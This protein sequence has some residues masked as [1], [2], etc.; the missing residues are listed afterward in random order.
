LQGLQFLNQLLTAGVSDGSGAVAVYAPLQQQIALAATLAVHPQFTTRAKSEEDLQVAIEALKFL[1]NVNAVIGPIQA[2]FFSSFTFESFNAKRR[3]RGATA[4]PSVDSDEDAAGIRSAFAY[5]KS[6]F[7]QVEDIWQVVGWTFNCSVR[8]DG[9]WQAWKPW[10]EFLLDILED[11]WDERDELARRTGSDQH[12]QS[13]LIVRYLKNAGARTER[14]RIMRAVLADGSEKSLQAFPEVFENETKERRVP[15]ETEHKELNLED[16]QWGDYDMDEE[17]DEVFEDSHS[18]PANQP[19]NASAN[20][21]DNLGGSESI[22]LRQR[23][24]TLV[25]SLLCTVKYTNTNVT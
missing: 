18:G 6:L 11:D 15:A 13:S 5:D 8:W 16:D 19:R 23:L 7:S 4:S 2:D 10:L 1:H 14:R 17:E 21:P 24:L 9:R 22:Q 3:K 25:C 20:S 12:Y